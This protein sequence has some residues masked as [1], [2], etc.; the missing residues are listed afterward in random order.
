[1]MRLSVGLISLAMALSAYSGAMAQNATSILKANIVDGTGARARV[2]NVR[3]DGGKII[4]V[5]KC[6]PIKGDIIINGKGLILAPGFI[7]THSHHDRHID[8]RPDALAAINQGVTTVVV[9]EDGDSA[10]P[11]STF[12][13][14]RKTNPSTINFASYVGHGTVRG[15]VMGADYKRAATPEEI[16]KMEALV[17][18]AMKEGALGLSTGLEYDPG[19]YSTREEVVALSKAAAKY[20]GRYISHMRSE[21]IAIEDAIDEVIEIGRQAKIPVQVSHLKIAMVDKW[22]QADKI[23]DKLNKARAEGIDITADVYPYTYWQ[24]SLDVL[25][26]ARDFTDRKAAEFALTHLAKPDGLILTNFPP[27]QSYIG[28]SVADIAKLRGKDDVTTF[29]ELNVEAEAMGKG[30][31]VMGRA[32]SDEDVAKL[33]GWEHSNI[34]SDGRIVDM[35]PRGSGSFSRVFA[36]LVRDKK[37]ISLETAVYK[38][39]G[40]SSAHMGFTDRG[41]IAKGMV[42]DL[43]LF[44]AAKIKDNAT[45]KNPAAIADGVNEVWVAGIPVFKDGKPTGA[46]P[47]QIIR[48]TGTK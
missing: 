48:R 7:D 1:M 4:C 30:S 12:F 11:L 36:W 5:G 42:A 19:I 40:L 25:L 17:E 27:D 38:M 3:I 43:V 35:H 22:G 13:D 47:G 16:A 15:A 34:C 45:F 20:N 29:L 31:G 21:D 8:K 23:I 14:A 2:G 28:K 33:I 44:D 6:S 26:P 46:T 24:S 32:M 18:G 10:L 41:K 39:T 37:Q 9:G